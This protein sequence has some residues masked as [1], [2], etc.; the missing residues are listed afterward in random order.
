MTWQPATYDIALASRCT[1]PQSGLV[2]KGLGIASTGELGPYGEIWLLTHLGS[3][4]A[5]LKIR[6]TKEE[7]LAIATEVA[8]CADWNFHGLTG[9]KNEQP[10]LPSRLAEVIVK[11]GRKVRRH[12]NPTS[13]AYAAAVVAQKRA[14]AE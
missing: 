8:D 12:T 13:N 4:H 1:A 6:G 5:F 3:G 11:H 9:Y 14:G 7:A 10:D 2:Y